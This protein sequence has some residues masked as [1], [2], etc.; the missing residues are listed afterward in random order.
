[1]PPSDPSGSEPV[2]FDRHLRELTD[3][4]AG[5]ASFTELSAAERAK[6]ARMSAQPRPGRSRPGLRESRRARQLR[7]PVTGPGHRPGR[8][9]RLRLVRPGETSRRRGRAAK[10][11]KRIG[12]V[13]GFCALL[14]VLHLLGFGPQ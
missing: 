10:A 7:K 3:G 14:Y 11:A 4:T 6:A 8:R 13:V 2:D 1:M 5:S 9:A 12:I